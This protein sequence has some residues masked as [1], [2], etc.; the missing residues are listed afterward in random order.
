MAAL[1]DIARDGL[2]TFLPHR[3]NRQP[4]V[5]RG[6]TADELWIASLSAVRVRRR[7]AAG[8]TR[9]AQRRPGTDLIVAA[10][11]LACS[12]AAASCAGEAQPPGP[13]LYRQL[14]WRLTP[15]HPL[16]ASWLIG[17]RLIT[18]SL[19]DRPALTRSSR[20]MNRFGTSP[21]PAGP[22]AHAAP[23]P[24]RS[25]VVALLL[26]FGWWSAPGNDDPRAP[27]L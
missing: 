10:W 21:S 5:V 4:V 1:N 22:C 12:V 8:H 14:R 24:V 26:G 25:F 6:L 19:L 3:L 23:G 13:W 15:R 18:H 9:Y 11:R 2:V 17:H 7:R 16:A 27:D 20:L